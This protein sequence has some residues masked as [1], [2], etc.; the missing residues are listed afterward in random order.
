MGPLRE[1]AAREGKKT[2]VYSVCIPGGVI[3]DVERV[4]PDA[5]KGTWCTHLQVVAHVGTNDVCRYGSEEILSGVRRLS[6]LVK[7]AS[8]ASGMKA[9]LTI[10]SIVDRT[11][12]GPLVQSRVEGLNQRLRPFCDRVGCRFLDL[13]HRV[14]GFRVPLDRSGVHYT[15][16]AATR[17]AGVVA[18]AG[19]FF[20][21]DGLGQVL[22]GQQ[23]QRVRGKVR[24]CGDQAAIG[25][26]IVSCGSCVGKVPE[27]QALIESTEAVIVIGTESWLKPEINSAEI[28]TKVQTVFR[29]DRLHATGGG[30]FV[31]VSSSLSCSE[32]EVDS[33][34]ELLW[35][36]VTL[37]NRA[38]LI[39]GSFYRPPESAALVAEQ[40]RENLE[41][42]SHK[43][44]QHVIALGG[45]FNLP[46]IDWDTQMFRT[47]GRDRASSD[48]I[49]SALSE[50]YLEQL[51]REPTRGDNILDLLITNRPELFD[52]LSAEQGISDHK[53]VAASLNMEV[54]RNIK[55]REEGL[56]V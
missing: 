52:S 6:D 36:E 4:L 27:L 29:K 16:Q 1:M 19:R 31:A 17:V 3:P 47:G 46:D 24:T 45:D 9:E 8:L 44:S 28:F 22:K 33:S 2:N 38:R 49:L 13:R 11:D 43:F 25:I 37:N 41:Y 14:V 34:C 21:L 12:C 20:R 48:I 23:P 40:L 39:I 35:V 30:V 15:Q 10:C 7:T 54:N 51:N 50:N 5:M 56:S 55:K 53:A 26:V 32:V 42:I 18:W